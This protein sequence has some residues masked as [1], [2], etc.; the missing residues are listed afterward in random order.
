MDV[1]PRRRPERCDP[2]LDVEL[3]ELA[4]PTG[5]FGVV[6]TGLRGR[7]AQRLGRRWRRQRDLNLALLFFADGWLLAK[8]LT[9]VGQLVGQLQL[10]D[11][12]RCVRVVGAA[13]QLVILVFRL[14]G[15]RLG[16]LDLIAE[17]LVARQLRSACARSAVPDSIV[18]D[19]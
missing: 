3:L 12:H 4:R 13:R 9:L 1:R 18:T 17:W 15:E 8:L 6:R 10:L 11:D 16:A 7:T 14:L 2:R 19:G 5:L